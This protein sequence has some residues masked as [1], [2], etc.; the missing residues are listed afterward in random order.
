[1]PMLIGLTFCF[2]LGVPGCHGGAV[3]CGEDLVGFH[4]QPTYDAPS[5]LALLVYPLITGEE[6]DR[7]PMSLYAERTTALAIGFGGLVECHSGLEV[8]KMDRDQGLHR[9]VNAIRLDDMETLATAKM[10]DCR[11]SVES[12][13]GATVGER[14]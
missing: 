1:M 14:K 13:G 6:A 3:F 5:N 4:Y 12:M 7:S 11:K 2:L 10:V 8:A 9:M